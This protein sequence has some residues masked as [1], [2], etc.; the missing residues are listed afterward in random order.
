MGTSLTA[1]RLSQ[2]AVETAV[3]GRE[4][5]ERFVRLRS[6]TLTTACRQAGLPLELAELCGGVLAS[7]IDDLVMIGRMRKSEFERTKRKQRVLAAAS[8]PCAS[9]LRIAMAA[10]PV[11]GHAALAHWDAICEKH[12]LGKLAWLLG[13]GTELAHRYGRKLEKRT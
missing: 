8:E 2:H 3:R 10:S 9:A 5:I 6:P 12:E 1:P 4:A 13:A 7:V 11:N